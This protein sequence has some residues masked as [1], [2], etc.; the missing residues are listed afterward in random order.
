MGELNYIGKSGDQATYE[1]VVRLNENQIISS[2]TIYAT[3]NGM[4]A[5]PV[6]I[7]TSAT[8]TVSGYWSIV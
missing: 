1:S 8:V 7:A 4:S 6:T 2:F 5:G 3:I